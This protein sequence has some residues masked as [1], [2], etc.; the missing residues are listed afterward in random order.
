MDRVTMRATVARGVSARF[1]QAAH[2][3]SLRPASLTLL[4]GSLE[5]PFIHE[6]NACKSTLSTAFRMCHIMC[7]F[8]R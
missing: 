6:I 5:G 8:F 7:L 3:F 1:T 2:A 4:S